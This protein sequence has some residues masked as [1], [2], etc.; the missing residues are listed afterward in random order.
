MISS[1]DNVQLVAFISALR[2]STSLFVSI[3][4]PA[5]CAAQD[6]KRFTIMAGHSSDFILRDPASSTDAQLSKRL[7]SIL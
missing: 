7:I 4:S 3:F 5:V 1:W 6:Y 2:Y